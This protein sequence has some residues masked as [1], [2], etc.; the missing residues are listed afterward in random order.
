MAFTP[1]DFNEAIAQRREHARE[2]LRYGS[3][4]VGFSRD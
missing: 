2:G 1:F 4:V 3:P